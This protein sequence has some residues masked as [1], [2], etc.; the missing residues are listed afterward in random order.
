MHCY[1][2]KYSAF[3]S[4][5]QADDF[6]P[7]PAVTMPNG[8]YIHYENTQFYCNIIS[9]LCAKRARKK[10]GLFQIEIVFFIHTKQ[11]Q[12]KIVFEIAKLQFPFITISN[13]VHGKSE[14]NFNIEIAILKSEKVTI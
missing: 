8:N 10:Q 12:M 13:G 7:R 3:R 14:Y 5:P 6:L 2:D 9:N 4:P 11:F 1:T